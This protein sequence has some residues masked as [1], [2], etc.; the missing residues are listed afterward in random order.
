MFIMYVNYLCIEFAGELINVQ[1]LFYYV[2]SYVYIYVQGSISGMTRQ[3]ST[4]KTCLFYTL[5]LT[6][7]LL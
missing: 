5:I 7:P 3:I 6:K 4:V 2:N 1:I